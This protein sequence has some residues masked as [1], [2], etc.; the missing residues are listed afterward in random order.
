ML[1]CSGSMTVS[2]AAITDYEA[3]GIFLGGALYYRLT[4]VKI[5]M[6]YWSASFLVTVFI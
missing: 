1:L 6:F 3:P 4:V 2:D 5:A